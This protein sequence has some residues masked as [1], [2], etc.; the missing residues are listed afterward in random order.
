[1]R[2]CAWRTLTES[3]FGMRWAHIGQGLS[4][5]VASESGAPLALRNSATGAANSGAVDELWLK[6]FTYRLA[7][8][9]Q[10]SKRFRIGHGNCLRLNGIAGARTLQAVDD[11]GFAF[12]QAVAD[13]AQT[14]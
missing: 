5:F 10:R 3:T 2:G 12:L 4:R 1:G 14:F 13:N 9:L 7:L 11:D 8:F 6:R